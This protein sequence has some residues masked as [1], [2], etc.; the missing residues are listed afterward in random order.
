MYYDS[1]SNFY[2]KQYGSKFIITVLTVL[3]L[4]SSTYIYYLLNLKPNENLEQANK[5]AD[6]QVE[7]N[8]DQNIDPKPEE[9]KPEEQNE[10]LKNE[11]VKTT[12][13]F[14]NLESSK[15]SAVATVTGIKSSN[16]ITIETKDSIIDAQLIGINLDYVDVNKYI[17]NLR[18]NLLNKEVK[19]VFDKVKKTNEIYNVYLYVNDKLYNAEVLKSGTATLKSERT[20][21]AL[22]KILGQAQ[23]EARDNKAGVWNK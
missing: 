17:D 4:A 3:L 12:T 11:V 16:Q 13:Y 1:K 5:D 9:L 21:I 18:T 23:K 14:D 19:V 15:F 8:V 6:A 22:T 2:I 7:Q 10:S 20:N